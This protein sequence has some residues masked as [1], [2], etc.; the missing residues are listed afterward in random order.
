M[1]SRGAGLELEPTEVGQAE[2]QLK[3]ILNLTV[4]RPTGS[5]TVGM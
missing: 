5:Q 2:T 3:A 1:A 4:S